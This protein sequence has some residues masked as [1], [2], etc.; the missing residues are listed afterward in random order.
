LSDPHIQKLI[1]ASLVFTAKSKESKLPPLA[2][3]LW[4]DIVDSDIT[5]PKLEGG[6]RSGFTK[7]TDRSSGL[8]AKV[9]V[10]AGRVRV[11]A[12]ARRRSGDDPDRSTEEVRDFDTLV[13]EL[14]A[15]IAK[16]AAEA[17]DAEIEIWLRR[18]CV[19][20]DLDRCAIYERSSSNEVRTS[21]MWVRPNFPAFPRLHLDP[22]ALTKKTADWILAGNQIVFSEPGEIPREFGDLKRFVARYG[23][24][25]SAIMPRWAGNR[26]IGAA[27][28]G[29]FRLSRGWNSQI[30]QQL[31]FAVR[32]F[33]NAIE[34]KQAEEAARLARAELALVQRR[35]MMAGLIGSLAHEL[36]QPLGAIMSNLGGVARLLSRG[37]PDPALAATA[38][39]NALDDTRRAS[40][41]IKRVRAMFKGDNGK[42]VALD[43][44]ALA[45]ETV[46]M[47]A[48]EASL[49]GMQVNVEAVP[50][51]PRIL[52][53]HVLLKQCILNLLMNAI[54][55]L[56]NSQ[57]EIRTIA[58]QIGLD[59][60]RWVRVEVRDSGSGI[61]DS[62]ANRL[63]EPFVTT[64]KD[65]MGLGLVV[66]RSIIEQYDG[67]IS[68]NADSS[69]AGASLGFTLPA[70][71]APRRVR[72][73]SSTN[74]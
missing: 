33:G 31:E 42:A 24:R 27:S 11:T 39:N 65:G 22:Q 44:A 37:N 5:G 46:Q 36:N 20:L 56:A 43:L 8:R 62:V 16:A 4:P 64:K 70:A 2:P 26:V 50:N 72:R 61:H 9:S 59:G 29:R 15:G 35:S 74:A 49:R 41:I 52:G 71:E 53:D 34:R 63:F 17:V 38:I 3:K 47:I 73:T 13:D 23:P 25:A 67:K 10:M 14:S 68:V 6:R 54:E 58:I 45:S 18:I 48:S 60:S 12:P 57:S 7:T 30:L 1:H 40:E 51:I 66:T 28:F 69:G 55:S 19:S 21:H 32:I